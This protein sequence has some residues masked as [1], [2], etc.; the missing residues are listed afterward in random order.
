MNFYLASIVFA[1]LT[2]QILISAQQGHFLKLLH[3][4]TLP[5]HW[6]SSE[7]Q[8][9]YYRKDKIIHGLTIKIGMYQ[10]PWFSFLHKCALI[11]WIFYYHTIWQVILNNLTTRCGKRSEYGKCILLNFNISVCETNLNTYSALFIL[12]LAYTFRQNF[13]Q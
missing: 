11:G 4:L 3:K 5:F 10:E 6:S 1:L 12:S 13:I 9:N 2:A 8:K 7:T